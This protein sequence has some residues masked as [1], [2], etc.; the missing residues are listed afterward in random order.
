MDHN[1]TTQLMIYS[2][3]KFSRFVGGYL[4]FRYA[5]YYFVIAK[6]VSTLFFCS[7]PVIT[8]VIYQS[9]D[10]SHDLRND[11]WDE[12]TRALD[13]EQRSHRIFEVDFVPA[14]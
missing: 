2:S 6:Y 4:S 12:T 7:I 9:P 11:F 13:L 14:W 8:K 1:L 3:A 5:L 10:W